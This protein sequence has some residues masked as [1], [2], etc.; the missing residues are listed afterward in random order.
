MKSKFTFA[1]LVLLVLPSINT[2]SQIEREI[3]RPGLELTYLLMGE[4]DFVVT[5]NELEPDILFDWTKDGQPGNTVMITNEARK[6]SYRQMNYIF[7]EPKTD[8]TILDEATSIFISRTAFEDLKNNG[9]ITIQPLWDAEE[10]VT[11]TVD[12][13][14][15]TMMVVVNGNEQMLSVIH[16]LSEDGTYE[17]VIL[18]NADYPLIL[19]MVLDFEVVLQEIYY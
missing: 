18:D 4:T 14:M 8:K 19:K 13:E 11:L 9:T 16:A 17:Y 10:S 6:T 5:V 12:E 15:K 3:F 7:G 2:Y 1:L